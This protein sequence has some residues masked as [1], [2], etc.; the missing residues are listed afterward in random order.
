MTRSEQAAFKRLDKRRESLYFAVCVISTWIHSPW[1]ATS[2]EDL[3]A[4]IAKFVEE[5]I[6]EEKAAKERE[7]GRP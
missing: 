3:V 7:R 6:N 2:A 4:M 5:K 1:C